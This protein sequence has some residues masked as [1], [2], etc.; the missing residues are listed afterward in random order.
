[1]KIKMKKK[2][3]SKMK[4]KNIKKRGRAVKNY[5]SKSKVNRHLHIKNISIYRYYHLWFEA[6][7]ILTLVFLAKAFC[8]FILLFPC[9]IRLSFSKKI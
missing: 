5:Y 6:I 7:R 4:R 8:C 2:K 9:F 3:K 1:M